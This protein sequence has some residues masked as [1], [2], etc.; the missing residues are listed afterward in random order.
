MP[1]GNL[2]ASLC[3]RIIRALRST[4]ADQPEICSTPILLPVPFSAPLPTSPDHRRHP[5][6]IMTILLSSVACHGH[7]T[8]NTRGGLRFPRPHNC[9]PQSPWAAGVSSQVLTVPSG[10]LPQSFAAFASA[11][12]RAA[13]ASRAQAPD[14][15]TQLRRHLPHNQ[16]QDPETPNWLAFPPRHLPCRPLSSGL[17]LV[18]SALSFSCRRLV[19]RPARLARPFGYSQK[20]PA[21]LISTCS[22]S[23]Q[24]CVPSTPS[25]V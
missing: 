10:C 1:D 8:R 22:L 2:P 11:V 12:I 4:Q 3:T 23:R 14:P 9:A 16:S 21:F 7:R 15:L 20:N 25:E 6:P 19:R 13:L 18:L 17:V 5:P 24:F